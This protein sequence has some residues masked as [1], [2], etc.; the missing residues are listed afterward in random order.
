MAAFFAGMSTLLSIVGWFFFGVGIVA[1]VQ[2][3]KKNIIPTKGQRWRW[4]LLMVGAWVLGGICLLIANH[5]DAG[6]D[7]ANSAAPAYKTL[8]DLD[9]AMSEPSS[10]DADQCVAQW[11]DAYRKDVGQNAAVTQDQLD[12]WTQWCNEGKRASGS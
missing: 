7:E 3:R 8:A 6:T 11:V 10:N 4:W 12:E 9:A 2:Q 1:R 5:A